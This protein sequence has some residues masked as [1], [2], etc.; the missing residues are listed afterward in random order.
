M[1]EESDAL[2][3]ALLHSP[4]STGAC[5]DQKAATDHRYAAAAILLDAAFDTLL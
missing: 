1:H 2:C 3:S 4:A 5:G